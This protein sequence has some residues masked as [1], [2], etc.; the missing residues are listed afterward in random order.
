MRFSFLSSLLL[1]GASA[2]SAAS[3][4]GFDEATL[5]VTSKGSGVGSGLKEKYSSPDF[6]PLAHA[7][8]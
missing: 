6:Q 4:W 3:S 2:V 7:G 5:T 8:C 1:V